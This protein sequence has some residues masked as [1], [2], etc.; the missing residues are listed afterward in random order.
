MAA[1]K[2]V[3]KLA[4]ISPS[5]TS[6]ALHDMIS[7]TT[8]ERVRQAMKELNYSPNYSAQM[9]LK[10]QP[11]LLELICLFVKIKRFSSHNHFRRELLL[12]VMQDL[13]FSCVSLS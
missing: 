1:I 12:K 8:K 2:N 5:T 10:S 7:Q 9:W 3:A 6:R 4:R 11:I 13:I